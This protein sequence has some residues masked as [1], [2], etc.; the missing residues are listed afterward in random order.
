MPQRY[1]ALVMGV[2]MPSPRYSTAQWRRNQHGWYSGEEQGSSILQLT[3]NL[4]K[5]KQ[6][7][8]TMKRP[9]ELA[10][11]TAGQQRIAPSG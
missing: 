5:P 4:Q 3:D 10:G 2:T 6:N 1:S 8:A 7:P 9:A 11:S